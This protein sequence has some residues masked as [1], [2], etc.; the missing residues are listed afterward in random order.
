MN[1]KEL[2]IDPKMIK[3]IS[4]WAYE[5]LICFIPNMR[6]PGRFYATSEMAQNSFKELEDCIMDRNKGLPSIMQNAFVSTLDLIVKGSYGMPDM[7]S[8]Y[9]FSI[10]EVAAF[11]TSDPDAIISPV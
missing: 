7:H 4:T 10:G 3:E 5:I 9:G 2:E 11:D 8:V 6:V 1:R